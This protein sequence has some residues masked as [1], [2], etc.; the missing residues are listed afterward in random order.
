MGLLR[1]PGQRPRVPKDRVLHALPHSPSCESQRPAHLDPSL[2][3]IGFKDT[4]GSPRPTGQGEAGIADWNQTRTSGKRPGTG[5]TPRRQETEARPCPWPSLSDQAHLRVCTAQ[6]RDG[7]QGTDVSPRP[8]DV[9]SGQG[10]GGPP[11]GWPGIP[12]G[13]PEGPGGGMLGP[14][15]PTHRE[16]HTRGENASCVRTCNHCPGQPSQGPP[17]EA[18]PCGIRGQ[19]GWRNSVHHNGSQLCPTLLPRR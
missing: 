18:P 1:P 3:V 8:R 11:G 15:M 14:P 6:A 12:G 16:K 19:G 7:T 13:T 4:P 5:E 2:L 17:P 9:P 10:F